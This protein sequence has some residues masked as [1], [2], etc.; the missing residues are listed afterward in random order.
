MVDFPEPDSP[1][2][3]TLVPDSIDSETSLIVHGPDDA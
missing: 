2:I 3:P 1:T